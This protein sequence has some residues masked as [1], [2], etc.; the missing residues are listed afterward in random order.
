[1]KNQRVSAGLVLSIVA[2]VLALTGSAVAV[3]G[4]V[5]PKNIKNGAVRTSKLADGAVTTTKMAKGAVRSSTLGQITTR[6][7]TVPVAMASYGQGTANCQAGETVISGGVSVNNATLPEFTPV[8]ESVKQGNGWYVRV[9]NGSSVAQT[10]T[11][12]AYCLAA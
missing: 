7:A 9:Q 4:K 5:G 6:T 2:V 12:E 3:S 10:M 8:V 11:V 1:V